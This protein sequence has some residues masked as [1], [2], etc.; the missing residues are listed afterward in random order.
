MSNTITVK[1]AKD[2][3]S[4]LRKLTP[5]NEK[6]DDD[7]EMSI[8]E[9]VFFMAPGLTQLARRGFTMKELSSG[10]AADGIQLKPGTLN[11]YL[12]EYLGSKQNQAKPENT[13]EVG[14]SE[15]A[16]D[17]AAA[18]SESLDSASN[19]NDAKEAGTQVPPIPAMKAETRKPEPQAGGLFNGKERPSFSNPK[20]PSENPNPGVNPGSQKSEWARASEGPTAPKTV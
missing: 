5:A 16:I 4:N 19:P 11:R 1:A 12:N 18:K 17:D 15:G 9:A 13:S 2:A 7:L 6:Y 14:K 8:K 10:L 20:S 3:L